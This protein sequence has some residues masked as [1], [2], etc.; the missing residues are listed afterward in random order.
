MII[1]RTPRQDQCAPRGWMAARRR[2]VSLAEIVVVVMIIGI[3]S[4]IAIPRFAN[5][6]SRQKADA[7]ARRVAADLNLTSRLAR[8][9][10]Q[11]HR[12]R[13][14]T[15]SHTY[16][17]EVSTDGLSW[18]AIKD[19][20]R[21][22]SDYAV[23]LRLPPYEARIAPTGAI[24]IPE[25]GFTAPLETIPAGDDA[26]IVYN[27]DGMPTAS[28]V[29]ALHVGRVRKTVNVEGSTGQI[30]ITDGWSFGQVLEGEPIQ[31]EQTGLETQ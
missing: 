28:G 6:A 19:M 26:L 25:G 24:A 11:S 7:A 8:T 10:G 16:L 30:T 3:V 23:D 2:G 4:A 15:G 13:V 31:L 12:L 21:R 20:D 29:V 14:P 1:L 5:A 17:V 18:A 22:G 9:K 27:R